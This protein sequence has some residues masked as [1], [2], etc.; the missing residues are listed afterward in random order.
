MKRQ[1]SIPTKLQSISLRFIYK[2][3]IIILGIFIVPG[4]SPLL[5]QPDIAIW[6]GNEQTFGQQGVP[7]PWV[8]I[9]GN[10]SNVDGVPSLHYT[11]NGGSN[12]TL[13]I[14]PDGRRLQ[15]S[16]DFNIDLATS[17]LIDGANSV[18][19][20]ATDNL[21]QTEHTVT[22][23]YTS[24]NVWPLPYEIDW[25]DPVTV[26][27]EVSQAVDGNWEVT[28]DGIHTVTTG[29]D[30]LVAIGDMTWADYEISVPVT[31]HSIS[32]GNGIGVLLRWM[33]H[34]DY[35]VIC[36]QP[37]CGYLPLGAICW[38]RGNR[39][40]I[41]G[42]DGDILATQIRSLDLETIYMFKA[43][44][45]TNPGVGGLYSF[46]VWEQSETEPVGWDITGQEAMSD[47]QNGSLLLI[48]HHGDV[49][50]G[51]LSISPIPISITN[52]QATIHSG[53][54]GATI[55]WNTNVPASSQVAYGL[56][57]AYE[58]GIITDPTLVTSHSLDLAG[59]L[60]DTE[61]HYQISSVTAEADEAIT[62][63]L[64]FTTVTSDIV[65]DD[66]HLPLLN[67]S[68]WTFV[69]PVGDCDYD[70]VGS[71]TADAWLNINVPAGIEHQLW[72]SGLKVPHVLQSCN[73]ADFEVEAKFESPLTLQFQEQGILV[74]EDNNTFMRFEFY[75][76]SSE[77][78][79]YVASFFLPGHTTYADIDISAIITGPI[80]YMRVKRETDQ[81]TVTYSTD[82]AI[83]TQAALFIFDLT[84]TGIGP[85][86]G[87]ATGSS[88]PAHTGSIDY[89]FNTA[90]PV[91]PEDPI[92]PGIVVITSTPVTAAVIGQLY[93]YDV[94]A[95]GIP[96]PTFSLLTAPTG[97]TIDGTSGLI[98]WT[99]DT[100]G[101][102]D[103]SVQAINTIPN[104]D[105]Q[106]FVIHVPS[107]PP[108]GGI[109]SDDFNALNL[110][111]SVWTFI[112]P[113][114]GG[115]YTLTGTCTDDA[116]INISVPG[117]EEHQLWTDGIMAPHILQPSGDTDFEL[118]VKFESS[119]TGGYKEQGILIKEDD[120]NFLRFGFYSTTSNTNVIA[121]TLIN[122]ASNIIVNSYIG[123]DE[124]APL[125]MLV[126][127]TGN[128]WTLYHSTDGSSWTLATTFPHTLTVSAV[129]TYAGNYGSSP[130]AH[131]SSVD[132]FFNTASPVVPEDAPGPVTNTTTGL[133][134]CTIQDAI[135]DASSGNE[136]TV[137]VGSYTES[138]TINKELT[139]NGIGAATRT[140]TG[141]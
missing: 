5:S 84:V 76:N 61:Y 14:G 88:S 125:Y 35:P 67:T 33:G 103:V 34:T 22:V 68:L 64:M 43:R 23:N 71:N 131:T 50:F 28:T 51:N 12:V 93:T 99:P 41:Y 140:L 44:V 112:D 121:A 38:Y 72:T 102:F 3:L 39:L 94:E 137:A 54:T 58:L 78:H 109:V 74:R 119:L 15:S 16:G 110:D 37:K 70:L 141:D 27:N 69:D 85:Y 126:N 66:F 111:T 122:L 120:N 17:D 19:I 124:M 106:D 36:A 53:N 62:G 18:I 46:K 20:T 134:Y 80:L 130:P 139:I 9:L 26:A 96:A 115:G 128:Q 127:R 90:A 117:G 77:T 31:I 100:P 136:I 24:T 101:N 86:A 47:P 45:E 129:G 59:L 4:Y 81:W 87:N 132:Y 104:V 13:S 2:V 91:V 1:T 118:E 75:S 7:Q 11:L 73:N 55:S 97:M 21:G 138:L 79:V 133:K 65:S 56:T 92:N 8:N 95:T 89:F 123:A 108:P 135:D 116:W 82:G 107:P 98:E 63:D 10:V 49:T 29:Y 83:W 48:S 6:Y 25:Q 40:E 32:G 114:G 57:S 30:R 105:I 52:I 113:L 60:P 42:N